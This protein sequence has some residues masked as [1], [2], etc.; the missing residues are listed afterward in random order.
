MGSEWKSQP[1]NN[2]GT[3]VSICNVVVIA[4]LAIHAGGFLHSNIIR[5]KFL[6]LITR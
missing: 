3:H 6:K 1:H 5:A 4:G 2:N